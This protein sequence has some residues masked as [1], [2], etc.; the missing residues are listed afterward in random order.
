MSKPRLTYFDG[1]GFAEVSRLA[2]SAAKIEYDDIYLRT[3]EEFLQ[4]ITDGK[5]MFKQVPLLEIDGQ[6]LIGSECILR[7]ICSK[8]NLQG[9]P[10]DQTKIEMLSMGARDML[11]AGFSGAK[12][13]A[14]SE[15]CEEMLQNAGKQSKE[16]YL[17]VFEKVLGESKS[18]FLVGDSLTMADLMFFDSVSYV[19]DIS[20]FQPLLADFPNCKRFIEHFS[21]Q[22][23]IKE[24]LASP[25][26]HP[27]PSDE[28][29]QGV[30]KVLNPPSS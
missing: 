26:R 2:L 5:L 10:E 7:Y 11:K 27:P 3:R 17:P 28:Y 14:T 15:K 4:L 22:P 23:G 18:G 20:Q 1:R 6:N 13:Q 12:F 24:Y 21:S 25:R 30:R 19:N 29:V 9:K 8:G 16:R